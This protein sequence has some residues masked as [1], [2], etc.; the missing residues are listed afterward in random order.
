MNAPKV[1]LAAITQTL[2]TTAAIPAVKVIAGNANPPVAT[3]EISNP[4]INNA[5]VLTSNPIDKSDARHWL[6]HGAFLS[7]ALSTASLTR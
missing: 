4:H 3:A 5:L 6:I 2:L 7:R 1:M